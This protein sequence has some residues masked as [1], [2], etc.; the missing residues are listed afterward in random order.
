ML[1]SKKSYGFEEPQKR[2]L[3]MSLPVSGSLRGL[4]GSGV[5]YASGW[6]RVEGEQRK[7]SSVEQQDRKMSRHEV[8]EERRTGLAS[9]R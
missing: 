7:G 9:S 6:R 2:M 4:I 1:Y 8:Q 3:I 5:W